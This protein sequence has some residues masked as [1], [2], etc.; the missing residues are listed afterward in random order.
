MLDGGTTLQK[1]RPRSSRTHTWICLAS[2][3]AHNHTPCHGAGLARVCSPGKLRSQ[4]TCCSRTRGEKSYGAALSAG[5]TA[6]WSERT[7]ENP[8]AVQEPRTLPQSERL[9]WALGAAQGD[10]QTPGAFQKVS[11]P[12]TGAKAGR[13][14]A[15]TGFTPQDT[16]SGSL[17]VGSFQGNTGSGKSPSDSSGT[18][19][20]LAL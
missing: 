9:P 13:L 1:D 17:G 5:P 10:P 19:G 4:Q 14:I 20:H 11:P 7:E 8:G 15:C 3:R 16:C 6:D 2:S 18:N 12:L